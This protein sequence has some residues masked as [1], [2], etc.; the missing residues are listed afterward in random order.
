[1][2]GDAAN[3][4]LCTYW[5][6]DTGGRDFDIVVDGK[7]IANQ[8]LQA[9]KPGEFIEA[10]YDIPKELTAGKSRVEVKFQAK[11]GSMAGGLFD[12]RTIK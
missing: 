4:L 5:G 12:C 11:P 3:Q 1:V 8:L 7:V 10:T 6:S 2:D 9:N